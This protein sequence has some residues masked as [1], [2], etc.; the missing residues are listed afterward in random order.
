MVRHRGQIQHSSAIHL[1]SGLFV[2]LCENRNQLTG[3][4]VFHQCEGSFLKHLKVHFRRLAGPT[5]D[6]QDILGTG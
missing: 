6:R 2:Q 3:F 1:L 5:V 4:L